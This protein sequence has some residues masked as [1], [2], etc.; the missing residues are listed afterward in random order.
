[1]RLM[2]NFF[3]IRTLATESFMQILGVQN[4]SRERGSLES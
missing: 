4:F 3:L 2:E 1:M